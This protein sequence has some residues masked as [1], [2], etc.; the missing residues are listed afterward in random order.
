[1]TGNGDILAK[2]VFRTSNRED[3][4]RITAGIVDEAKARILIPG[5]RLP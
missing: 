1:M 5:G 2:I 4:Q 3:G